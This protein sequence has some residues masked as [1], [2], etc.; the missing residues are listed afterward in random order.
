MGLQLDKK[1]FHPNELKNKPPKYCEHIISLNLAFLKKVLNKN[2]AKLIYDTLGT[3]ITFYNHLSEQDRK[4][5]AN[6]LTLS[7]KEEKK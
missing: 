1:D 7:H 2:A 3:K 4:D 5:L 6:W